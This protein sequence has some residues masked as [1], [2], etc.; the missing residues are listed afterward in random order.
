M[1][2]F[3][4]KLPSKEVFLHATVFCIRTSL[5]H[6]I[7]FNTSSDTRTDEIYSILFIFHPHLRLLGFF[8]KHTPTLYFYSFKILFT[9]STESFS[10]S[11]LKS[12]LLKITIGFTSFNTSSHIFSVSSSLQFFSFSRLRSYIFEKHFLILMEIAKLC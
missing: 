3:L 7:T 8:F 9:F 11:A 2:C 1:S 6:L 10:T 5:S 4:Q 12:S